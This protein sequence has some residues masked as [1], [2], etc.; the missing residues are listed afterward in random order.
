MIYGDGTTEGEYGRK[1]EP[2]GRGRLA[3]WLER[4]TQIVSPKD[5]GVS[6][7]LMVTA[8]QVHVQGS[9]KRRG[10]GCVNSLPGSAWL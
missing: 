6:L 9:A 1:E 3:G 4:I 7:P 5:Y 2:I 8:H 10:L